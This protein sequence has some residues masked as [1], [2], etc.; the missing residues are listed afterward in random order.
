MVPASRPKQQFRLRS[1]PEAAFL[2][3]DESFGSL[4][5]LDRFTPSSARG[6]LDAAQSAATAGGQSVLP[7]TGRSAEADPLDSLSADTFASQ[8]ADPIRTS[9]VP[10]AGQAAEPRA[11]QTD[12][13]NLTATAD[14][15]LPEEEEE[16]VYSEEDEEVE[17]V[18][19]AD[20]VGLT[21]DVTTSSNNNIIKLPESVGA[22]TAAAVRP[23]FLRGDSAASTGRVPNLKVKRT[24]VSLH[25]GTD[26]N[27]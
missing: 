21:P 25:S 8:L 24:L 19:T 10:R 27:R 16:Y 6:G 4:E 23:A 11:S 20:T 1:Q 7:Q 14:E 2:E 13:D 26:V 9:A 5:G 22:P 17:K 3:D 12:E 18:L 15:T